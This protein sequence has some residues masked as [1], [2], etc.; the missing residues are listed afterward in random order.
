MTENDIVKIVEKQRRFFASGASLPYKVRLAAL[1]KLSQAIKRHE[2]NL[3]RALQADLGKS[4]TEGLLCEIGLVLSAISWMKKHLKKLMCRRPVP[5]PLVQFAATSYQSP[6]PYGN[7]LII[8][9]WNYP[10]LLTLEPLVD[11][12]AAGNTAVV[13]PSAYAPAAMT[14]ISNIVE[15]CF[16]PDYV[17]VVA[18]GRNENQALLK[19]HFDKIFFTGSKAVGQEVMRY[20]S[21]HLTP[22]TLE[23][24]GKSPCIVEASC[25]LSLA[26]KRIVFG[27][28]LNCGQTC[29]APDYVLCHESIRDRFIEA[30]IKEITAQFGPVPLDNP[31]YGK[32]INQKHFDRL[33]GL[34]NPDKV[35]HGGQSNRADC[36]IAPT[37][38]K[39]V[40]WEDG[41]MGEEIFGPLLPI[42]TYRKLAD[43]LNIINHNPHPLALYCFT[44][45]QTVKKKVLA[46]CRFGGG[47]FNDTVIHLATSEMPFG[48]VGA[49]GMGSYHGKAG[50]DEFTHYRSIVDKKTWLDLPVRYQPYTAGNRKLLKWFIMVLSI[51]YFVRILPAQL[52]PSPEPDSTI[53]SAMSVLVLEQ[54]RVSERLTATYANQVIP[55][56]VDPIPSE[57]RQ[58]YTV[59]AGDSLWKIAEHFLNDGS[60]YETIYEI[61][62]TVIESRNLKYGMPYST[63]YP[64]QV[65]LLPLEKPPAPLAESVIELTVAVTMV[66][67]KS[68]PSANSMTIGT[69][70]KGSILYTD[71]TD[72]EVDDSGH[73]WY[74]V[75]LDGN[76][77]GYI[78]SD[79][80]EVVALPVG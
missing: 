27:K 65:L 57:R 45:N 52:S 77:Y 41:V 25:K 70:S 12:L 5:T 22:V 13:K 19:Q 60:R 46:R 9:P 78:R 32:I 8:S 44:E 68:A 62:K 43:A 48:G 54:E 59:K 47:C 74:K 76:A 37:V 71:C 6:S 49:S 24:G 64:G 80:V 33:I 61:N 2:T 69:C 20:A 7:V 72:A 42:L 50:F 51:F 34:I 30:V 38:M 66:N 26:A 67:I 23:L 63:I 16:V 21:E 17:A 36:R 39:D 10:V 53:M 29:V 31:D 11:A 58:S 4:D 28:F 55:V 14:V 35:V 40:S 15:E 75:T 56:Q 79:L 1:E 3:S 73:L 18:G